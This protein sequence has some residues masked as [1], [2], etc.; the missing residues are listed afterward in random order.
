MFTTLI[1]QPIFNLLVLIYA[2]LPGHNFG[3]AIIIFTIVTRLLLWPLVKK[4]L[5]H[6]KAMRELQPEIKKIK[7]AAKGDKQKESTL[8]MELYKERQINPFA[9]LGIIIVQLP[10]LLGLYSGL[11]RLVHNHDIIID[12]AYP[13]LRNLSW[14]KELAAD[15]TKFDDT[16]FGFVN[17]GRSALEKTGGIYW[18]AMILVVGAA[19]TQYYQ[20]KQLMPD[21]KDARSLRS[22][23]KDAGKGKQADSTETNAAVGRSMRY[24]IPAMIFV[25]AL[26][27]P[28]ALPLYWVASGIIAIIQQGRV[29]RRDETELSAAANT[30]TTKSPIIEGEIVPTAAKKSKKKPN[31]AKAKKAKRRKK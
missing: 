6:A 20:S 12:F 8:T 27:L 2:L 21:A 15:I 23:L 28:A 3:L 25:I 16:L 30:A 19:I 13:A 1:V 17:L 4:Q 29:L 7:Q 22:L 9:S 10:I 14:M 31:P 24:F 26:R 11:N 18:P 5:Y